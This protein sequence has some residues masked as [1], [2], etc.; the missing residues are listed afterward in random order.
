[1]NV[2]GTSTQILNLKDLLSDKGKPLAIEGRKTTGQVTSLIAGLP[3]EESHHEAA[4]GIFLQNRRDP[5]ESPSHSTP[6]R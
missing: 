4:M 3:K 1:M 6:R 2:K 5:H